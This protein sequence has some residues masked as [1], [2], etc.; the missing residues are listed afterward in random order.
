MVVRRRCDAGTVSTIPILRLAKRWYDNYKK[1]KDTICD[2]D[3]PK[4]LAIRGEVHKTPHYV[5]FGFFLT[6][7]TLA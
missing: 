1:I 4:F 5:E 2:K 3:F 7:P 6:V